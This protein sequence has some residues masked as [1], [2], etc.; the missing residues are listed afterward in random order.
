MPAVS[1]LATLVATVASF[2][3]GGLWYGPLFGKAWMAENG[4]TAESLKQGFN[5]AKQYGLTFIVSLLASYVFGMF[6]GPKPALGFAV[7][8]GLAAGAFWVAGSF[9]TAYLFE[10]RSLRLWLINGGYFTVQF[11]LIGLAF[12][13]LG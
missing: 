4:F 8:A 11:A 13:L 1:L 12:G 10:R 9:A 3:L 2:V 6:L 7:G 5:P